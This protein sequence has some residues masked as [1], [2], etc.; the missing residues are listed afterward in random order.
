MKK[1]NYRRLNK[2]FNPLHKS[3]PKKHRLYF[4]TRAVVYLFL[5]PHRLKPLVILTS[6]FTWTRL[7]SRRIIDD[8]CSFKGRPAGLCGVHGLAATCAELKIL[9]IDKIYL[10]RGFDPFFLQTQKKLGRFFICWSKTCAKKDEEMWGEDREERT[11]EIQHWVIPASCSIQGCGDLSRIKETHLMEAASKSI[12]FG[13]L[14]QLPLSNN[15]R[16]KQSRVRTFDLSS[17][18]AVNCKV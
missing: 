2:T 5:P 14:C 13:K 15:M 4:F 1:I 7:I 8:G 6:F 11:S 12:I 3:S 18:H 9:Q 17:F 16:E 10:E